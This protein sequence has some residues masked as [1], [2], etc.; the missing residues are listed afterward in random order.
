MKC[1]RD[2]L[3]FGSSFFLASFR[4]TLT[5][6]TSLSLA[7]LFLTHKVFQ[8]FL[9]FAKLLNLSLDTPKPL[10]PCVLRAHRRL[11]RQGEIQSPKSTSVLF[12][13]QCQPFL[14]GN[15]NEKGPRRHE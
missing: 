6:L 7:P 1:F 9:L 3:G 15:E 4:S 12:P 14:I 2:K 5:D 11:H 13:R 8:L 10:N